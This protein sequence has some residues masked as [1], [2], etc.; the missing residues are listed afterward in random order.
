MS[1]MMAYDYAIAPGGI[2]LEAMNKNIQNFFL[3]IL[4]FAPRFVSCQFTTFRLLRTWR[5]N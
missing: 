3:N 5:F 4:E 2:G 1:T